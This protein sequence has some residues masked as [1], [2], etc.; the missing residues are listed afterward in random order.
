MRARNTRYESS[1]SNLVRLSFD[2]TSNVDRLTGLHVTHIGDDSIRIEWTPIKNVEGYVIQHSYPYPYPKL[3]SIRT[4]ETNYQLEKLVK[5]ININIKVSGYVKN[6]V[7]RPASISSVLPG[8]GGLPEVPGQSVSQSTLL[9]R[10]S[11]A[12]ELKDKNVT[13]GIY[14]GTT[15]AELN[16]SKCGRI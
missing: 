13:Y 16:E 14:Y 9:L 1:N 5:G 11:Q 6:Y 10:W 7:G 4:K 3:E 15:M 2:D 8:S 12:A